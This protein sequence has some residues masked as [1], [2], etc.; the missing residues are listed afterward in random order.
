M[1]VKEIKKRLIDEDMTQTRLAEK[2]GVPK[3]QLNNV[4]HGLKKNPR[5][6]KALEIYEETGKAVNYM[7]VKL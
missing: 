4:L 3:Q 2:I 6:I 1:N 5:I 7:R